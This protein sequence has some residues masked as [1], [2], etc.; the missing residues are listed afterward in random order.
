MHVAFSSRLS[1][2]NEEHL[3]IMTL[4]GAVPLFVDQLV[5]WLFFPLFGRYSPINGN[6]GLSGFRDPSYLHLDPS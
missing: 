2:A 1:L 4:T 6:S 3:R 5:W